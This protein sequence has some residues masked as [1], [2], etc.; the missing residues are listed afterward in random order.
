MTGKDLSQIVA[1]DIHVVLET[2]KYPPPDLIIRTG[3]HMR[4]SGFFLFQSPYAEY[5]FS[6]KNWPDFDAHELDIAIQDFSQR[7]RKFGK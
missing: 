6:Q 1:A 4:H 5:Y 3:N 2:G 7:N